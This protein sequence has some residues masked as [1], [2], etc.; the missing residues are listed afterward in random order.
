M[1]ILFGDFLKESKIED[2]QQKYSGNLDSYEIDNLKEYSNNSSTNFEWLLKNYQIDKNNYDENIAGVNILLDLL[3]DYFKRF[4]R[5]K[6][7]LPV[8]SRDINKIK[9]TNELIKIVNKHNDF[10][11]INDDPD[12]DVI[13]NNEEWMVFLPST[14][15]VSKKWGWSRFCVVNDEASFNFYNVDRKALIYI[16]HKFDYT[17][18]QIIQIFPDKMFKLWDYQDDN[19]YCDGYNLYNQL[20]KID[21]NGLFYDINDIINYSYLELADYE[22]YYAKY[23]LQKNRIFQEKKN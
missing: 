19:Y 12:V 15:K 8:D 9:N 5:I 3:D 16:I 18:H 22:E 4:L 23:L 7:S 11:K 17:K 2:L 1:K 6:K 21:E 13:L 10:D 20:N 14:Y